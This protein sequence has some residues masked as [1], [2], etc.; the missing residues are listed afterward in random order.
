MFCAIALKGKQQCI[1]DEDGINRS[2]IQSLYIL[3]VEEDKTIRSNC[4]E[5]LRSI[6]QLKDGFLAITSELGCN[7]K[8]YLE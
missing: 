4:I 3:V 6:A 8:E 7:N 1:Y 2:I 5:A